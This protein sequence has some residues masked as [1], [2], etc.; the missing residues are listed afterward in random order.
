MLLL[1]WLRLCLLLLLSLLLCLKGACR[2]GK[3]GRCRCWIRHAISLAK[4][5]RELFS[6]VHR[7]LLLLIWDGGPFWVPVASLGAS[8]IAFNGLRPAVGAASRLRRSAL[9]SSFALPLALWRRWRR[10]RHLSHLDTLLK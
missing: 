2:Y 8:C 7:L 10:R 9:L 4:S 3:F 5:T 6:K 1:P